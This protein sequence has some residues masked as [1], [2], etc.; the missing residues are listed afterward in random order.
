MEKPSRSDLSPTTFLEWREAKSLELTPKFQRRKVW[1][2]QERSFLIDTILRGMPIPPIYIRNIYKSREKTV[3]HQ[4]ID[5]QQRI[6]AVL[7]YLD[8]AF[9][10]TTKLTAAYKGKRFDALSD[11]QQATILTYRFN[12]ETFDG[13]SDQEI[14]EVFRR[15]N[16][17]SVPLNRQE[18]RNGKFFGYLKQLCYQLAEEHLEFWRNNRLFSESAIAR[19]LEVQLT[20]ELII[21]QM[22]GMQDKKGS[23]DDFYQAF[24]DEFPARDVQYKRFRATIDQI[25]EALGADLAATQFH[26]VPFFYTLFC[27]VYHRTYGLPKQTKATLK[28]KLNAA[29]RDRLREVVNALSEILE[30]EGAS[31]PEKI[32]AFVTASV[33]QTDNIGP[34]QVRFDTLYERA[35]G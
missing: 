11:E 21:A 9:A 25:T 12:C 31:Y 6:H 20:S 15:L 35:F 2:T 17:Y 8:G 5:G 26:R 18:L 30:A 7:D 22:A 34:R 14:L 23:I 3:V 1:K 10:L 28:R 24:D 29:E 13:I 4:V 33:G 19:M 16:T 27:V 32:Q